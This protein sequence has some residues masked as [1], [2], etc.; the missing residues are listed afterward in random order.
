MAPAMAGQDCGLAARIYGNK[1]NR[2]RIV[3]C[4]DGLLDRPARAADKRTVT[5]SFPAP[6]L[7]LAPLVHLWRSC[8]AM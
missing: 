2:T 1:P 4:H 5:A 6:S 8:S 3:S 7:R